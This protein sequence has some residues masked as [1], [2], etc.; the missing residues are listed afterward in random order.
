MGTLGSGVMIRRSRG[1]GSA[2]W[3]WLGSLREAAT[4]GWHTG[5]GGGVV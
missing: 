4:C 5:F 1:G 2:T 3:G